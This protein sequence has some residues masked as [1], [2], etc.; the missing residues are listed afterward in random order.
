MGGR[1]GYCIKWSC[2]YCGRFQYL[3]PYY[4]NSRVYCNP[5]CQA[6]DKKGKVPPSLKRYYN[7]HNVWNKGFTQKEE[8]KKKI[9]ATLKRKGIKPPSQKGRKWTKKHRENYYKSI[10]NIDMGSWN[11]G[12]TPKR[13]KRWRKNVIKAV[14]KTRQNLAKRGSLTN[15]EKIVDKYLHDHKIKHYHE[16][17]VGGK[18]ADFYLPKERLFLEAD[19]D[20]WHRDKKKEVKRDKYIKFETNWG[21]I[22]L[23]HLPEKSI[24][25]G[26]W[27]YK[28]T[29]E[30]P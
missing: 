21:K 11:R 15:L 19:G 20:Y 12:R 28:A 24:K 23:I 18:S 14:L 17:N 4:A 16:F 8:T 30:N 29:L 13:G 1:K 26:T 3:T 7:K 6:L 2:R 25:D 22:R 9:S 10:K 5:K 27:L